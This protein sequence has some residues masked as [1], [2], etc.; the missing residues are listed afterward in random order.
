[1]LILSCMNYLF[2]LVVSASI[3][4]LFAQEPKAE[5]PPFR[6][7]N[8][9]SVQDTVW[10]MEFPDSENL[11]F[12]EKSGQLKLLNLKS[13]KITSIGGLPASSVHGQGGLMDLFLH[14]DYSKNKTLYLSYTKKMGG[15]YTTAIAMGILSGNKIT[16]LKDIFVANNAS[17][18]S[19]HFGSR[20]TTDGKGHL[21]FSVGDRG[22]RELA[23]D[24]TADQGKIHRINLDGSLPKDNPFAND[25]AARKSIWSLGHRNPQGLVYDQQT[26][27]LWEQEHGPRGGDEINKVEKGKNYGWPVITYGR[28]YWGINTK[29][30]DTHKKGLEQ[31]AKYF[32]PSIAPSGLDIYRGSQFPEWQNSLF[33][34]ALALTHINRLQLDKNLK[35]I[36]EERLLDDQGERIRDVKAGPDGNL[37]FSTDSGKISRLLKAL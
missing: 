37:Y 27:T 34:G 29:I 19:Q 14:P 25:P 2:L 21:F 24:L 31:P 4:P 6:V 5:K 11:L 33:S 16:N 28:E 17:S 32:V 8:L 3:C 35:I 23:Q 12:T 30:G 9:A 7:E 15:D 22:Q 20:I 13:K 26:D 18:K 36:K 10:S 1:M